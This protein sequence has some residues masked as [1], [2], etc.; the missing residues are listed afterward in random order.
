MTFPAGI[1]L[2]Q[3]KAQAKDL[4]R[5]ARAGLPEA[6]ARLLQH[7]S[8]RQPLV[9]AGGGS[10][11]ADAQLVIRRRPLA[12]AGGEIRLADAQLVIAR[13]N[14]FP[15]WAR[16]KEFLLFRQAVQAL[17][18]GD[19]PGLEALLDEHPSLVGYRCHAGAPYEQGYFAGATLLHHVAGNPDRGSL[20]RNILDVARLLIHRGFDPAV[21]EHTIGLLLTSKRASEA[22]VALPLVDLLLAA[23]AKFDLDAPDVLGM[24]LLNV[25]PAT[26]EALVR[27][28]ARMDVRHAAALGRIEALQALLAAA[29]AAPGLLEEALAYACIRGQAAAATLLLRHGAK[30]DVLVAPGGQTPRTALHEAANRG[31]LDL[32]RILLGAGAS[33]AIVEPRWAGTA[34]GWAAHGGHPEVAALLRQSVGAG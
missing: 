31:H 23:G 27:R 18:A 22:G 34:A 16:F 12:A 19:L 13:Q 29:P 9:P 5:D 32:V 25:A 26:A 1:D 4:L 15:S 21:A 6:L 2:E 28:G 8:R 7:R 11:R 17:D 3:Y 10:R 20:P 33:A 30:G 14:G 24:P